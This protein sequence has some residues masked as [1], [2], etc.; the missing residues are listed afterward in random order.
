M[1]IGLARQLSGHDDIAALASNENPN[2]CS[3][4]VMEALASSAF[5]PSR[6]SDPACIELRNALSRVLDLPPGQI[7]VGNG[8]EEMVAAI[9]RAFLVE[10]GIDRDAELRLTRD[11]AAG[12]GSTGHQGA[13]DDG[14]GLRYPGSGSGACNRPGAFLSS[15]SVEPG[16]CGP[17]P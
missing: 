8:S 13:D 3:P 7:V 6:Y 9:S 16:R 12:G 1:N 17:D 15:L 5:N 4:K 11:R 2:G 14:Y 10:G